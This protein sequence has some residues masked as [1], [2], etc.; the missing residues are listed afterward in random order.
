VSSRDVDV[1]KKLHDNLK[2][3]HWFA[4]N[5]IFKPNRKY[6][7]IVFGLRIDKLVIYNKHFDAVE[8]S[9]GLKKT[10]EFLNLPFSVHRIKASR[11]QY[12]RSAY[13]E[14]DEDDFYAELSKA[15][16]VF[17]PGGDRNDTFRHSE[18]IGLNTIPVSDIPQDF[19]EHIFGQSMI[20]LPPET[21]VKLLK[22]RTNISQYAGSSAPTRALVRFDYWQERVLKAVEHAKASCPI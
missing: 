1:A 13:G 22:G 9:L 5:P 6:T 7:G 17:S 4:Q 16:Y 10:S 2:I 20:F 3:S 15:S 12:P 18:A 21:L 8:A 11:Y 19:Y 14:L